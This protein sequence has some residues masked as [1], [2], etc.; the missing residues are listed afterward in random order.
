MEGLLRQVDGYCERTDLTYWAEPVNAITNLA[1]IIAAVIMFQ[2]TRGR[3][4]GLGVLLS[5]ILFAIGVGSYLFHTHAMIWSLIADVVPIG[6]YILVYLYTANITFWGLG[7]WVSAGLAALFIPYAALV[8]PVFDQLPFFNVSNFYW[9]VPILI[10][11]YAIALRH[12]TPRTARG[13]AI[14]GTILC[15]SI[16]LRSVD[17]T[18]CEAIPLGTHF[19]WHCLNGLMLGWMIEVYR[20]HVLAARGGA[21]AT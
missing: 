19:L 7:K 6:I 12:R 9:S 5:G 18:F 16:S 1:F 13:L 21:D 17:E 11:G 2:R 14:G 4:M 20:R 10:F 15:V 3:D 8:T